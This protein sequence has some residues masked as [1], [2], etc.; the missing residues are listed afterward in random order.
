M[1]LI[2]FL[3]NC[4]ARSLARFQILVSNLMSCIKRVLLRIWLNYSRRG[5]RAFYLKFMT[6]NGVVEIC[7]ATNGTRD[8]TYLVQ[9][10]FAFYEVSLVELYGMLGNKESKLVLYYILDGMRGSFTL[11]LLASKKIETNED[12]VFDSIS[13]IP[14]AID[15]KYNR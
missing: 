2:I 8:V 10:Y 15:V 3:V 12:I 1:W 5:N 6:E 4:Y 7:K 11:D 14:F 9:Y 13:W